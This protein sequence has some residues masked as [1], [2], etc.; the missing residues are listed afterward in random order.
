MSTIIVLTIIITNNDKIKTHRVPKIERRSVNNIVKELKLFTTKFAVANLFVN[1]NAFDRLSHRTTL[2]MFHGLFPFELCLQTLRCKFLNK[3]QK[4]CLKCKHVYSVSCPK[5]LWTRNERI[6][7]VQSQLCYPE[8]THVQMKSHSL[9]KFY[10][11]PVK[12]SIGDPLFEIFLPKF[13]N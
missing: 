6:S 2:R 13:V 5:I 11:L 4:K 1:Q 12:R 9:F 8:E 3:N 7:S 10:T